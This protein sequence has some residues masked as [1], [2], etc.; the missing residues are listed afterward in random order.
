MRRTV[1][2]LATA[3]GTAAAF[4][5]GWLVSAGPAAAEGVVCSGTST[6]DALVDVPSGTPIHVYQESGYVRVAAGTFDVQC[7]TT[8]TLD[9][10][11]INPSTSG[12]AFTIDLTTPYTTSSSTTGNSLVWIV[13]DNSAGD[14]VTIDA[15][16]ATTSQYVG[17]LSSLQTSTNFTL[18]A[19]TSRDLSTAVPPTHLT[20]RGGTQSD[21][22]TMNNATTGESTIQSFLAGNGGGDTIT[23]GANDDDLSGGAGDDTLNGGSGEDNLTPGDGADTSYA[24]SASGG[25]SAEVDTFYATGDGQPDSFVGA[26]QAAITYRDEYQPVQLSDNGVADDGVGAEGDDATGMMVLSGGEGNDVI[27]GAGAP[28]LNGNGGDDLLVDGTG[29]GNIAGGDGSDTVD[30]SK[31][32]AALSGTLSPL[33]SPFTTSGGT[34]SVNTV[35]KLIGTNG[36]DH[37]TAECACTFVPGNGSDVVDLGSAGATYVAGATADG[38]D[39]VTQTANGTVDYSARAAALAISLDGEADDGTPTEHDN[40]APGLHVR[41]GTAGDTIVGSTQGETLEGLGG[42]D[43]VLGRGG[44][45]LLA[46]G[47]GN[48]ALN[49]GNGDDRLLGSTGADTLVGGSGDDDLRGD[50]SANA[51]S[52]GG[53]K[54]DGGPGDDDEY[55]YGG[56]DVFDQGTAENGSDLLLGGSG[57]DLASY[58]GRTASLSLT[59][60]G[61]F[62]D[63]QAGES[64]KLASDVENVT[65]GAGADTITGNALANVLTGGKGADKLSGLAGNDTLNSLDGFTD[66]LD[67]GTGTDRAHRDSGD[68]ATSVESFF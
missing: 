51:L 59:L 32:T 13:I 14:D 60:D 19:N 65:G 18:D 21:T 5:G 46:G 35:E 50:D 17:Y 57:T 33:S 37:L 6:T 58:A 47:S 45:D 62:D 27:S 56:N 30:F 25:T 31:N 44:S 11:N 68:P 12:H 15:T 23:G 63:G 43:T 40:L 67:G 29:P 22:I 54:L 66:T 39:T 36:A 9:R 3:A 49:G 64:D 28:Y 38:A 55:G 34:T 1:I 41:G 52:F 26:G 53:D 2:R 7:N 20:V 8:T 24:R 10:L 16:A 42:N 48:D 61:M 4:A